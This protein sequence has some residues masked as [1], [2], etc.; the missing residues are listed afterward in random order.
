ML[1]MTTAWVNLP[2][3]VDTLPAIWWSLNK[4]KEDLGSG[5]I[6]GLVASND[7]IKSCG[8]L[9]LECEERL[10]TKAACLFSTLRCWTLKF[11][12]HSLDFQICFPQSRESS[13]AM[14]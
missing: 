12:F 8:V 7:L 13:Q 2:H 11:A 6:G 14:F 4:P 10:C 5:H 9:F 3:C 1:H